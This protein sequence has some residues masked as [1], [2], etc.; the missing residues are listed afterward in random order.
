[1]KYTVKIPENN[2]NP[3]K[4]LEDKTGRYLYLKHG[5]KRNDTF[6][7]VIFVSEQ[8][9]LHLTA[10]V[11]VNDEEY[12]YVLVS[13]E[14]TINKCFYDLD[15]EYDSVIGSFEFYNDNDEQII[16]EVVLE[17]S[18][19]KYQHKQD[20]YI[21]IFDVDEETGEVVPSSEIIEKIECVSDREAYKR[22]NSIVQ[23]HQEHDQVDEYCF[24]IYY[25][26]DFEDEVTNPD[27]V[28][29]E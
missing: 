25:D 27:Y 15:E 4:I 1:M 8:Y 9:K 12:S 28:D 6:S 5:L 21:H 16:V 3:F 11:P 29:E 19:Y 7:V 17:I 22:A 10:Y 2:Y 24:H 23:Y 13:L 26:E 20:Y 14:D 18:E